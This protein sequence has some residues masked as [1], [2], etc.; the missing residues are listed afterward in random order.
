MQR[1]T[2]VYT[3]PRCRPG[4]RHTGIRKHTYATRTR[5]THR[6]YS[7]LKCSAT[8]MQPEKC[9]LRIIGYCHTHTSAP[10]VFCMLGCRARRGGASTLTKTH[11]TQVA[12]YCR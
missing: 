1:S 9:A 8:Y 5:Y 3:A 7:L 11:R 6:Y 4:Y 10:L 2:V 12:F